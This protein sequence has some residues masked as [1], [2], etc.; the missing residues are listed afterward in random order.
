MISS[1]IVTCCQ[2]LQAIAYQLLRVVAELPVEGRIL[3]CGPCL[4]DRLFG[5]AQR[6]KPGSNPQCADLIASVPGGFQF[7]ELGVHDLLVVWWS[8]KLGR[9]APAWEAPRLMR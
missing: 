2:R 8:R 4:R 1:Q 7:R 3:H 6:R 9:T 5:I